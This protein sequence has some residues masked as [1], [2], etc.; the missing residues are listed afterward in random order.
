ML[1]SPLQFILDFLFPKG[2]A[3]RALEGM[4]LLDFLS[5]TEKADVAPSFGFSA[6]LS[7]KDPLVK[8]L[9]W[10]IKY[11]KSRKAFEFGADIFFEE[12]AEETSE[13]ALLQGGARPLLIPIP[14][15]LK[16]KRVRGGNHMDRLAQAIVERG[17]KNFFELDIESLVR[18]KETPPQTSIKDRR[19]RALNIAG[20]FS[21]PHPEKI[22][23]K[24]IILIDD[25]ATTGA[26]LKEA[27]RVLLEGGAGKVRSIALAH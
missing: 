19:R 12:L 27:R 11:H 24:T 1:E 25:V 6:Y 23:G 14:M 10:L 9:I 5:R 7:Y 3:E 17:G 13:G 18:T 8:N 22:T 4:T 15:S 2:R 20:V 21:V 16:R 26:T